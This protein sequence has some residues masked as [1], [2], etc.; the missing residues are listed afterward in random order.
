MFDVECYIN[1][2]LV[3][4]YDPA[5]EIFTSFELSEYAALNRIGLTGTL[6]QSLIVGFNSTV[7]DVPM[8]AAALAGFNNAQLKALSNAII[9]GNLRPWDI[10]RD[11]FI[12]MPDFI[13]HI[14]LI[15]VM[16]GQASLKAYGG[17]MH[18]KTIQDLPIQHDAVLTRNNMRAIDSYCANDLTTTAA[19]YFKFKTQLDLRADMSNENGIDL[20]SKSDAQISEAMFKKLLP[21][22]IYPPQILPGTQFFYKTP[23]FIKFKTPLLQAVLGM[24]EQSPFTISE[25]GAVTPTEELA[26][27]R[28]TI[29]A[30]TYQLGYGGLH[31]CEESRY[32]ISDA[33]HSLIDVDVISYYPYIIILLNLYPQQIG[34]KFLE[35][36]LS[37]VKQRVAAKKAG[38]KKQADGEKTKINGTFGKTGSKY[39][40]L[41]APNMM[42]QTTIT[43]QLA[44]LMQI[45][46]LECAG[47]SVVSANTDGIVIKCPRHLHGL[48]DMIVA[49]WERSTG[50]ETERVSYQALFSRDVNSYLAFK[51]DGG[52]KLKGAF[53]PPEPIGPSWPNPTN[54]I[55]TDA[56]IAY[57]QSGAD[58]GATIRACRD[59]TKFVNVRKV[60]GGGVWHSQAPAPVVKVPAASKRLT[61]QAH[62]FWPSADGTR[63][64]GIGREPMTLDAAYKVVTAAPLAQGQYLGK[65]VR[66]YYA[67]GQF[68]C[69][70]SATKGDLV[71]RSEG[72]KPC[73]TL[74]DT[75]PDDVDYDW[76]INETISMLKNVDVHISKA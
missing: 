42:I 1:Y 34:P 75:F 30:S 62:G 72:C 51:E 43:G 58:I 19:G 67:R 70:R 60:T 22:K 26:N 21:E 41:N 27:T 59:I 25:K 50:F 46:S 52:V 71:A 33:T 68:G 12:K 8:I 20:R 4:F 66:W 63:W 57:I 54:E 24:V 9:S 65:A 5:T 45:E 31:S 16:P 74:P 13:D 64:Q 56:M 53:A 18:C 14:D 36:F 15:E 10:E 11:Y 37:W 38:K 73:M 6:L 48:R 23:A 76:Y 47:I 55:C 7:Y 3:K 39:S 35:I 49:D 61:L 29:G 17:K 44:L 40:I 69:I 32:H 2:F 28:V